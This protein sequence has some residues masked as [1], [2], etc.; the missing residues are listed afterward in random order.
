VKLIPA[1][2]SLSAYTRSFWWLLLAMLAFTLMLILYVRSSAQVERA[3]DL[4][5]E[6][7]VLS[8]ELRQSSNDLTRM[9]R[10]YIATGDTRYQ[11]YYQE[12]LDIR[13][14]KRT[15]PA[16]NRVNYWEILSEKE[17]QE[18]SVPVTR[19]HGG[20]KI[21]MLDL[22]RQA[23]FTDAEFAKVAEAKNESDALTATERKAM[24]LFEMAGDKDQVG[25]EEARKLLYDE[26]Y[27]HAK[28]SIMHSIDD[29]YHF[30]DMRTGDLLRDV[31]TLNSQL[32]LCFIL[33]GLLFLALLWR[34][35]RALIE[36]LGA[37]LE[38][39]YSL[40]A[41]IGSGNFSQTIHVSPQQEASIKA[42]I[43]LTQH[44]LA[45]AEEKHEQINEQ[46]RRLTGL[47][48]ALSQCN[49]AIVR[50]NSELELFEKI[51]QSAVTYGGMKMAWIGTIKQD[52]EEFVPV[53]YYG[54]E[55]KEYMEG[56]TIS[57]QPDS[58]GQLGPISCVLINDEPM[59]CQNF[60]QDVASFHWYERGARHGWQSM[61]I[62]PL[63]KNGE[64][65][66]TFNLFWTEL[67]LLMK[68]RASC[69]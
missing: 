12:I 33:F 25:R 17:Q 66:G 41:Q 19:F 14:G 7:Y 30:M 50:S 56:L 24:H 26:S 32:R 44:K 29:A 1:H 20:D 47:Y 69:C 36:T 34:A 18:M 67:M 6:S 10:S 16:T 4:R 55:G 60:V 43:A 62:L 28:A 42:W 27:Q 3:K 40:L 49:Q 11:R 51:C 63:H 65:V 31:Q 53:A 68:L 61:A 8:E 46:N 38:E 39:I 37:P 13:D 48:N 23:G 52:T 45:I 35:R 22:M 64:V 21:S 57:R 9:A 54:A 58:N 5:F 2:R 15:R 59:W